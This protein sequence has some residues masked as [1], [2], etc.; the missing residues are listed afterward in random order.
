ML[1]I[2]TN[3]HYYPF[4]DWLRGLLAITVMFTHEGLIGWALS[5][6]FAVQIFF[7]LSGWL[8][9]SILIKLEPSKLTQFYF[10]RAVRI[11]IPYYFALIL[12]ILA[13]LIREP[14]TDKWI[15]FIFYKF[16]FVYNIFGAPQLAS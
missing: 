15:E 5:G 2:K 12:L 3:T 11:W 9:G 14:V 4:F 1:K 7:A 10:N 13:S 8:I 6:N 16:S